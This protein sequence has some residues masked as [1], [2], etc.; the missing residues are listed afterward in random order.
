MV[1]TVRLCSPEVPG[2]CRAS[3]HVISSGQFPVRVTPKELIFQEESSL[4]TNPTDTHHSYAKHTPACALRYLVLITTCY[5]SEGTCF[6]SLK[7]H[8]EKTE[9]ARR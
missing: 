4:T 8:T 7:T 5:Q 3:P 9:A 1:V 2:Q 6:S